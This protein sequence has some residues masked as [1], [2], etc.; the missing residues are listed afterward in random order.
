MLVHQNRT[1]ESYFYFASELLKHQNM[2][3]N[4]KTIGTDG[5]EQLS[6]AFEDVFPQAVCLLCTIHKRDNIKRKLHELLVPNS[7]AKQ[8]EE[9]TFGYQCGATFFTGLV[10]TDD[11]PDFNTKL[12]ELKP[13][14]NN[15]CPS[16]YEWFVTNEVNLFCSHMIRC[17][18]S[19]AGLGYPPRLYTTNNNESINRLL[20]D[21]TAYR[22][23]EWPT[24]NAKMLSLITDQQEEISK[25]IC[26]F[27]EYK[28]SDE[29]KH[30]EVPLSQWL[31]MNK[32]KQK[33][34]K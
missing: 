20:K 33:S 10:D 16:F 8:I 19:S 21:K 11:I 34:P 17:I 30:L 27:G 25:A 14:W 13:V 26:G 18:R 23:Q 28:F 12:E 15:I 6:R 2:L 29:Y 1:Y 22:K 31:K 3:K 4:L 5:E 7:A 9:S 24:F 32:E